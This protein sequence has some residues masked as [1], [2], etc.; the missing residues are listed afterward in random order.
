MW[1]TVG[2]LI[3]AAA[4]G[5]AGKYD[6]VEKSTIRESWTFPAG[7]GRMEVSV[8]NIEGSISVTGHNGN[9]VE[10]LAD[11]TIRAESAA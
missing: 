2:A 6:V 1:W 4:A 10:L 11:K 7:T 5:H 8:D 9:T 3:I